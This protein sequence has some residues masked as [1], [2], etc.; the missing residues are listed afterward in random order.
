MNIMKLVLTILIA[1]SLVTVVPAQR[2]KTPRAGTLV[3]PSKPAVL[4]SFLRLTKIEPDD[5][6]DDPNN[7]FFRLTNNSRWPIWLQMSGVS[8]KDYGE[9]SLYYAIED[10]ETGSVRSGTT[11]CHVCS[12]NPLMPGD[13]IIFS[14]PLGYASHD[15]RM[16][17]A[18][19]F[20]WERDNESEGG[21]YSEHSVVFYFSHLPPSILPT[22]ALSNNSFNRSA[23]SIAFIRE[24]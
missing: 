7:L 13:S 1:C 20:D 12:V 23:N 16:R 22:T 9:A 11:Q 10:K 19:S 15:T 3:A 17:I 5:P 8:K 14:L 24:T 18:Y 21:S 4:L 6:T 2:H